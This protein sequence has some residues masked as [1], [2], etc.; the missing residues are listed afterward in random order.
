MGKFVMGYW[1]GIT[2]EQ[3]GSQP[4]FWNDTKAWG[5]WMVER[6]KH[7]DVLHDM[8]QLGVSALLT[9][10]TLG[11][12]DTTVDWVA[13]SKL[14]CAALRLRELVLAG[15]PETARIVETYAKSANH[16]DPVGRELAQ[17]LIDIAEIARFA[18]REGVSRM[19]LEVSW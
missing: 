1:A 12:A 16:P 3:M 5:E 19:T 6:G 14:E 11:V 13:P 2:E 17:D 4:G 7:R 9:G 18:Q 8:K 10:T 15:H